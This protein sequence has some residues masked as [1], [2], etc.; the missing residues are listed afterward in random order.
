MTVDQIRKNDHIPTKN[1]IQDLETTKEEVK[2]MDQQMKV[3]IKD[4]AANKL[5]I[6]RLEL[7]IFKRT[8]FINDL[9]AILDYR[10]KKMSDTKKIDGLIYKNGGSVRDALNVTMAKYDLLRMQYLQ[11]M[12]ELKEAREEIERLRDDIEMLSSR[13]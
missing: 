7:G 3:L 9:Q 5:P 11:S 4:M 12:K 2:A 10:K 1:I 13:Y 6:M 8:K